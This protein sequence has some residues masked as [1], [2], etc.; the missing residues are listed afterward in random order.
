MAT[1]TQ[2]RTVAGEV[3]NLFHGVESLEF[4]RALFGSVGAEDNSKNPIA[5]AFLDDL[6]GRFR[7]RNMFRAASVMHKLSVSHSVEIQAEFGEDG[8]PEN[9]EAPNA[10]HRN[11]NFF[12]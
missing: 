4:N 3:E 5:E 11:V 2:P 7:D 1:I 12:K 9:G 10:S 8:E 6:S